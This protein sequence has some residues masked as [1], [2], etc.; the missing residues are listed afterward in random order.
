MCHLIGIAMVVN[1]DA[2]MT[3]HEPR[4]YEK[5]V[6]L[7]SEAKHTVIRNTQQSTYDT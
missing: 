2:I 4:N 3:K 5:K 6:P 7:K 1:K